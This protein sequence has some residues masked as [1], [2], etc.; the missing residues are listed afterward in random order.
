MR[1]RG[2]GCITSQTVWMT[3][4]V[5]KYCPAPFV[6]SAAERCNSSS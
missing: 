1:S 2:V 6:D 4:R 3:A 5:V